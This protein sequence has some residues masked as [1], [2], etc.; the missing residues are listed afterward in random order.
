MSA[1]VI[2]KLLKSWGIKA[3]MSRRDNY[4]DNVVAK[5]FF[6]TIKV[7]MVYRNDLFGSCKS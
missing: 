5:S 1:K 6:K 3:S 2:R 7:E 4:W